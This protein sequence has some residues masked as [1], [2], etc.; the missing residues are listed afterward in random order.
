MAPGVS[1]KPEIGEVGDFREALPGISAL[2]SG[3]PESAW[4]ECNENPEICEVGEI[5]DGS[6]GTST[7][8]S[9]PKSG[10]R[11]LF[12]S[13]QS[14]KTAI[15]VISAIDR[16]ALT[17]TSR[18][19]P[20]W[21]RPYVAQS[22]KSVRALDAPSPRLQESRLSPP[23]GRANSAKSAKVARLAG[24]PSRILSALPTPT[25]P[26]GFAPRRP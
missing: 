23:A 3:S 12:K 18:F 16:P 11:T 7:L 4:L 21:G 26:S 9:T 24:R 6:P 20:N 2:L 22:V 1:G 13:A 10:R 14:A 19:Q 25:A 15:S 17:R 8:R 5:R